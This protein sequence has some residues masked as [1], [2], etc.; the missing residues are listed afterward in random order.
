LIE[1]G[2]KWSKK[3]K[4]RSEVRESELLNEKI[5]EDRSARKMDRGQL[6]KRKKPPTD[7]WNTSRERRKDRLAKP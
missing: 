3:Q 2:S 1:N 5:K 6:I 4:K 7:A